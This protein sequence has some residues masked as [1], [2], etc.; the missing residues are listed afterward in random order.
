MSL[1]LEI[2]NLTEAIKALTAELCASRTETQVSK[3]KESSSQE[4]KEET[5]KPEKVKKESPKVEKENPQE[6]KVDSDQTSN[7]VTE[8]DLQALCMKIVQA[9]RSKGSDIKSLLAT[10]D[11]AKTVK[12][13]GSEHYAELKEKLEDIQNG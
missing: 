13:V 7:P 9:D 3:I 10:Y 4:I 5:V 11:G 2:K 6:A 1:E 12:Q 8:Q